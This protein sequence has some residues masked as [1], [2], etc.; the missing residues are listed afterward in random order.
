[1]FRGDAYLYEIVLFQDLG[2]PEEPVASLSPYCPAFLEVTDSAEGQR[3][4]S[5]NC[6][7][8]Y[9]IIAPIETTPQE[10]ATGMSLCHCQIVQK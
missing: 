4:Q 7:N 6:R 8:S 1:M 2:Q 5:N 3:Q 10:P 9:E